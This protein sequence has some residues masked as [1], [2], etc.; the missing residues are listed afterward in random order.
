MGQLE[1]KNLQLLPVSMSSTASS[2]VNSAR[3]LNEKNK[4]VLVQ[5]KNTQK[6]FSISELQSKYL[7]C[8]LNNFSI[9]ETVEHCMGHRIPI[10]FQ[11]L[12]K[13]IISLWKFE[14]IQNKEACAYISEIHQEVPTQSLL[15]KFSDFINPKPSP[16]PSSE[17]KN[18][19][20]EY[21][22][23]LPFF[24]NF[25]YKLLEKMHR[26]A[27]ILNAKPQSLLL[28][29]GDFSRELFL[30]I[31]GRAS[32][33]K[34]LENHN[35][36]LLSVITGPAIYGE[37]GFF[38]N[39]QRS[40]DI[41]AASECQIAR[42]A[43]DPEYE[44][45]FKIKNEKSFSERFWLLHAFTQSELFKEVPLD[46]I[47]HLLS[48]GQTRSLLPNEILFQE[49]AFGDTFY[50]LIQGKL[51][52]EQNGH[53]INTLGQGK[54]FGELALLASQGK[55]TATIK[56]LQ[57]CLLHEI[58]RQEFFPLLAKNLFLAKELERIAEIRLERDQKHRGRRPTD[59]TK[60]AS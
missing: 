42:F 24:H 26:E 21:L 55:R 20:I 45:L 16:K 46:T 32:I 47:D 14:V 34:R 4:K 10:H 8:L 44:P 27:R 60:K 56:A 7:Q 28:K 58:S 51:S 36:Q 33:Y 1:S 12:Y 5:V 17:K 52:V 30:L 53:V 37:G 25:S 57:P 19:S 50:I 2:T 31:K 29:Q 59:S 23:K 40:A 39:H 35:S 43:Y 22:G 13:L 3:D 9:Y 49:N 41:V 48:I 15:E 54:C 38:L 6:D 11:S 18:F